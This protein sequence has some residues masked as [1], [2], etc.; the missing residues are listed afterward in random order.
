MLSVTQEAPYQD[1]VQRLLRAADERAAALYPTGSRFGLGAND[2]LLRG[3][4]FFVACLGGQAVGC[5]GFTP[6]SPA[7]GELQRMFVDAAMRGQGV[8]RALLQAI[9][10]V[11][12]TEGIQAMRLE[13]G[14]ASTEAFALY[15]RSGYRE[16]EPFGDYA[17]DPRSIFMEKAL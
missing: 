7:E 3:V 13:T 5:G 11:A 8:G 17:L 10:D 16:R 9:E 1:A 6:T 15:R 4:R 14:A 2:L 12:R